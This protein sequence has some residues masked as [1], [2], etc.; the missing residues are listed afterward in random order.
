MGIGQS[1]NR[2]LTRGASRAGRGIE[3]LV[4]LRDDALAAAARLVR[5]SAAPVLTGVTVGGSALQ[6]V[7]PASP[8]DVFAADPLRLLLELRPAGGALELAADLAGSSERW[9]HRFSLAAT[10]QTAVPLAL[11]AFYGR[12]AVEDHEAQ[13]AATRNDRQRSKILAR[14]EELGLRHRLVTRRTSLVAISEDPTVDPRDPRRRE[15]LA[16]ELPEG[17]SAEGVG[18]EAVSY[19]AVMNLLGGAEE[20]IG[21]LEQF[22]RA[23][24]AP[25]AAAISGRL[26]LCQ[27]E[28]VVFEFEAPSDDFEMPPDGHGVELVWHDQRLRGRVDA[29]ASTRA[30]RYRAGVTLQ[31]A[32]RCGSKPWPAERPLSAVWFRRGDRFEVALA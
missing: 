19:F 23:S 27:P 24:Q 3:L 15:R 32:V 30:G 22:R 16:C 31:V 7:A 9:M 21:G 20:S 8:R 18:M 2:S 11:G 17:L 29:A 10:P 14:I 1:P 26:L 4:N 12:E 6:G 28:R 13:L 5:A 25:H